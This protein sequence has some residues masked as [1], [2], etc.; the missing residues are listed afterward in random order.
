MGADAQTL[1]VLYADDTLLVLCK[2]AGLLSVPGRG[3]DKQDCLSAR[4]QARYADALVVHRLD[5][6]TSGLLLMAR[7]KA[8]QQTLSQAFAERQVGKRYVALVH[9][10]LQ[11][12][13]P[14]AWSDVAL[15]IGVDWPNRPRRVVAAEGGKASLTRWRVLGRCG[16]EQTRVELEPVTGRSH[17]LRVHM[18]AIGHPVVG[19]PLY[20]PDPCPA[21]SARLMLHAARISFAHPL[22]AEPLHFSSAP[23]F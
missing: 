22:T 2:P 10:R 11:A 7:G 9:G 12:A 6:A 20:G 18:Q 8:A 5:M 23:E 17:Q 16:A 3:P 15:P 1:Q 4:A 14:G 19:D 13:T 21:N